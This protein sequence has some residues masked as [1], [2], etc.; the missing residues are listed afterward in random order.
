MSNVAIIGIGMHEFGRN[1]G[2]SGMDQGVVAVRRALADCGTV[3]SGLLLRGMHYAIV[4]EADSVFVDEART[5][6][7]LS[8]SITGTD[9]LETYRTALDYQRRWQGLATAL[10]ADGSAT[11][12]PVTRWHNAAP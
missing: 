5:P 11:S 7:I 6:L 3:S 1:D 9:E 2:I 12:G 10:P 4:D 8:A